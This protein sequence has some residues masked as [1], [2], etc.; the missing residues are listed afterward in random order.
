MDPVQT[1]ERKLRGIY[2]RAQKEV[3]QAWTDYMRNVD[4]E[5]KTLQAAYDAAKKSGDKDEIRKTGKALGQAKR[6]KTLHDK[7]Y[8][9][10]TAQLAEEI[11]RING[12]AIAYVNSCLPDVYAKT[13]NE[14][15][16]DISAAAKGYSFE[17]VDAG[18]V[19]NLATTDKTLLPYKKVNGKKDVRW[20]TQK[21]NSEVMQGILQG[22]SVDKIAGRLSNVLNMDEASAM[23]NA[24]TSV[25]SAQNKGRFDMLENAYDNGIIVKKEWVAAL[26]DHT[27]ESHAELDGELQ[28]YDDEFSNGLQFPGD[29]DGPPEEVYNCRCRLG[30]HV[31][32]VVDQE[33]GAMLYYQND[34]VADKARRTIS[35][36]T[37][38]QTEK[39]A[40]QKGGGGS[41][42]KHADGTISG[43]KQG[44]PM[45]HAEAD[46]GR[47]NPNFAEG[48]GYSINCQSCVCTYEAR[49]RG[50]NVEVVPNDDAHPMCAKLASN[51][52][53]AWRNKDGSPAQ[54]LYGDKFYTHR[55]AWVGP[56]PTAKRFEKKLLQDLSEDGRYFLGFGWKGFNAG[57]IVTLQKDGPDLV[58][59]D[60][61]SNKIYRGRQVSEYLEQIAYQRT[62]GGEKY[63]KWPN[64]LRVDDKDLDLSIASEIMVPKT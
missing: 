54:Y 2:N 20:N 41:G 8:R 60:P 45:S 43:V 24:R 18:T 7:H 21:V 12:Q 25:T 30:F 5:L 42:K 4:D 15:V 26:D 35:Q 34:I 17:L 48:G 57:H 14:V 56:L 51:Q 62:S 10:L 23:R 47:V 61:Q 40:A 19:R 46:T 49:L 53:L 64:V 37:K 39:P 63:V 22:E 52:L 58:I 55:S 3:G 13:Y 1:M 59:Y 28:D 44:A 50:F 16:S 6:D 36:S 29:P 33:S 9:D 32:G 11:S 27:R 31:V 38:T